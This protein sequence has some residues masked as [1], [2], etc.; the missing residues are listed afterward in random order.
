MSNSDLIWMNNQLCSSFQHAAMTGAL[1]PAM[2]AQF[3][4]PAL[5]AQMGLSP[6]FNQ[7]STPAQNMVIPNYEIQIAQNRSIVTNPYAQL[8]RD[9]RTIM[10][11]GVVEENMA[12]NIVAQLMALEQLDK[13]KDITLL[14]NSPGGSVTA[15]MSIYDTMNFIKNDVITICAGQAM[16]MGA[17]LLSAGTP[18]KR[19]VLPSSSVMVHQPSAGTQGTVTDMTIAVKEFQRLKDYLNGCLAKHTGHDVKKIE[20]D[21][22]RDNFKSAQDAVDYKLVDHLISTRDELEKLAPAKKAPNAPVV[23]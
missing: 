10:V 9:G 12:N 21:L 20:A 1:T 19:F 8:F 18:G 16:S 15:G 14:I 13:A 2:I 11:N 7:V 4:Q 23:K 3:N 6:A 22:E 5:A 17:F